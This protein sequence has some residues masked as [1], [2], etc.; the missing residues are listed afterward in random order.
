MFDELVNHRAVRAVRM[1][2]FEIDK[3][4][5]NARYSELPEEL[6]ARSHG[7]AFTREIFDVRQRSESAF[8]AERVRNKVRDRR[9]LRFVTGVIRQSVIVRCDIRSIDRMLVMVE[10]DQ[11]AVADDAPVAARIALVRNVQIVA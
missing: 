2:F 10:D 7:D 9:S 3:V 8:R 11:H 5:R 4:L 1:R 6:C